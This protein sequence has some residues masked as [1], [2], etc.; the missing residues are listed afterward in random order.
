MESY[1]IIILIFG[2]LLL[3]SL[4]GVYFVN[5]ILQYKVK[6]DN[7]FLA[8][9]E[10]IEQRIDIIDDMINFLNSNLEYEK[11]YQKRLVKAKELLINVKNNKNGTDN[12]KQ[13]LESVFSFINLENVYKNLSK[14]KEYLVIK[15]AILSNKEKLD[16]ALD[17][18]DKGV[19]VYNNYRKKKLIY[20]LSKMCRIPEYGC[21]NS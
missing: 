4:V 8:V 13:T 9:K 6:I 12:Y 11:S 10:I 7:S 19:I 18:Y 16:Y 21:Y 15:K 17:V 3:L 20:W 14:D 5:H 2:G 1:V